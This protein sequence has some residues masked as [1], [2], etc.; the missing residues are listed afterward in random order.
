MPKTKVLCLI[1]AVVIAS[2]GTV[3][4]ALNMGEE[5]VPPIKL[6]N[7]VDTVMDKP[8]G[9]LPSDRSA[10]ENLYIAQ[11]ELQRKG[12]YV[13]T[14]RGTAVSAGIA[15]DV[16]NNRVVIGDS[17]FKEM[18]TIGV[19]KNA[20]QLYISGD[21]YLHRKFDNIKSADNIKWA[22]TAA[23]YSKEGFLEK[24]GHFSNRLTGYILNDETIISGVLEKEENGL[25]TYRYV[26]NTETAPA[27]MLYE[28]RTNSNMRGFSVF[29][30]AE[31]IVTMD[32]D[33][34]VKTLTTDCKYK[35]PMF[36]GVNCV[37]DV[38]ETFGDLTSDVLPET[39]F[40]EQFLDAEIEKPVDAQPDALS[41]LMD[42]FSPYAGGNNLNVSLDAAM[43]GQTVLSGL[44]SAK[45][46]IENISNIEVAAKIGN[47]LFVEYQ[48]GAIYVTYQDFKA[49]TT[50][51]GIM[52]V[53]N[54][55]MPNA[56]LTDSD[57]ES[58][59][60]DILSKFTYKV[61]DDLCTVNL[62]LDLGGEQLNVNIYANV[63]DGKYELRNAEVTL[64]N[65]RLAIEPVG[66]FEVPVREG[67]YPE[68]LGLFDLVKNG[69]I[70]GN[71]SAFGMDVDVMFDIAT[72]SLYATSDNLAL[73]VTYIDKTI[74]AEF[75]A[76]KAKLNIDDIDSIMDLLRLIGVADTDIK[77]EMP[78]IS[79]DGIIAILGNITTVATDSG[80]AFSL[81][82]DDLSVA[83]YLEATANGW[84]VDKLTADIKGNVIT[85]AMTEPVVDT[86]PEVADD[87]Y[88]D[89]LEIITTF[90][91]PV[92]S[93]ALT[94]SYGANFA[95]ALTVN[96]V[97]Y[98]IEGNF[99]YDI[100]KNIRVAATVSNG[101]ATVL[102]ANVTV[103][104]NTV[105]LDV[106]GLKAALSTDMFG[107]ADVDIAQLINGIYGVSDEIDGIINAVYGI[108]NTALNLD[109]SA[110]D[111]AN[112]VKEFG[113]V[114]GKLALTVNADFVGLSDI[115]IA[116]SVN[117][118]GNLVVDLNGLQLGNV[119]LDVNATVLTNV[120]N[121]VAPS[122]D[123]YVLNLAGSVSNV[124]FAVS[125]DLYNMDISASIDVLGQTV[126]ARYVDGKI[127]AAVGK[128]AVVAN[129]DQ[130]GALIT[131]ITTAIGA[132]N[133]TMPA[134]PE[135]DLS[136]KTLIQAITL[137]INDA[138]PSIGI[139]LDGLANVSVNFDNDANFVNITATAFNTQLEVV[140]VDKRV[141]QLDLNKVYIPVEPLAAQLVEIYNN[142]KDVLATGIAL[143]VNTTVN[144]NGS[145]YALN[146]IV[147]YNNGLYV[148]A[149]IADNA[150]KLVA[151]D[152]YL[153]NNALYLDV[154]GIRIATELP[155][156]D[157][158]NS[159][160]VDIAT[161]FGAL[162]Q[163]KGYNDVL[164]SIIA[165][166]EQLPERF[167]GINYVDLL[168]ALTY[169]DNT[170][171]ATINGSILGLSDFAVTV[172]GT[173]NLDV[174]LTNLAIGNVTIDSLTVNANPA[175]NEVVAP[176]SE[177]VT[178]LE[179]QVAGLTVTAKLDL[180]NKTVVAKTTLLNK[181]LAL[182][183]VDNAIYV[184]Y[185]G[186][187]ANLN[188]ADIDRL[189]A[190]VN[191]FADVTMP[192]LN[193]GVD[194][195]AIVNSLAL[196]RN[197]NGY[198]IAIAING[199][200]V[201]AAF[202]NNARLTTAQIKVGDLD[203]TATLI[204]GASYPVFDMSAHYDNLADIA[205]TYATEIKN[206]LDAEGYGVTLDG[207]FDIN[208]NVYGVT[209]TVNY[210]NGL[211]VNAT[212]AYNANDV[213]RA[214]LWWVDGAVYA[215][216]G[217][218]VRFAVNVANGNNAKAG[219]KAF[220][221]DS[222]KGYNDTLDGVLS[223]IEDVIA[224][225]TEST[226]NYGNLLGSI[227]Y[228]NGELT[229]IVNGQEIG[230]S[231]IGLQLAV[232]NG[233]NA[234]ITNLVVGDVTAN[235]TATV[236]ASDSAVVAPTGDFT[237]NLAIKIDN[238]NTVYANLDLIN[239]VFNFRLD[240]MYI[241]YANNT[242]RINK[243]DMY[244]S[245]D[246]N[247][248]MDLVNR[249]DE[250]VNEFS[251]ATDSTM[252]KLDM[253]MFKNIDVKAIVKSLTIT[254]VGNGTSIGVKAFGFDI[255][256]MF[257]NGALSKASVPVSML[258]TTLEVTPGYAQSYVEFSDDIEYVAIDQILEDYFPVFEKLVHTNAW[259]FDFD[260]NTELVLSGKTYMVAAGSYFE[261]YFKNTEGFDTFKLRAH[262]DVLKYHS[263]TKVWQE[264]MLLDIVYK[265][266]NIYVSDTGRKVGNQARNTI[267]ITV[268]VDSILKC[269]GL[270]K[271]LVAVV[272]QIGE[273][274]DSVWKAMK[275]AETSAK[276]LSY[277]NILSDIK[278]SDGIVGLVLNGTALLSKLEAISFTAQTNGDGLQ[279]NYLELVYDTIS[280]TINNLRV[281]ASETVE[282]N[283]VTDYEVVHDID[284][285]DTTGHM[286]FN[287]LYELLSAF[288]ATATPQDED[289]GT[290]SFFIDGTATVALK[291]IGLNV[292]DID[293]GLSVKVDINEDN[294]VFITVKITRTKPSGFG[295]VFVDVYNDKGG[296]SYLY[297]DGVNDT[298]T[299]IRNS[300]QSHNY[301]SKCK[302][303]DN[304][305]NTVLHTA[306]R[307]NQDIID[308]EFYGYPSYR[309]DNITS[310]EFTAD[311]MDYIFELFNFGSTIKD[312]IVKAIQEPNSNDFG[313]EDIL[314]GYSY[315]EEEK[316]FAFNAD[317]T[318]IDSNLGAV[319]VDI[320]HDDNFNLTNLDVGVGLLNG[321]CNAKIP[322]E[323][324]PSDYGDATAIVKQTIF[325]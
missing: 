27:R 88:A 188:L 93:I 167:D 12:G 126:L 177:Y 24:F 96:G 230:L 267:K 37:E 323:L 3:S 206:L 64:G 181:E 66:E 41:V 247:R 257:V 245:G 297:Y 203:V 296:D 144:V 321:M 304:C 221:F 291:I 314:K 182:Y 52:G 86:I 209:A 162:A 268:S 213:I 189:I 207:Q 95:F 231:Q 199:I 16:Y 320:R 225:F 19:V 170:L 63:V 252:A 32:A 109:V 120:N 85:L 4:L 129:L 288:V 210:N 165:V 242:L 227:G 160:N 282:E 154:N 169:S 141:P 107:G 179:V 84:N 248:I 143:N 190:V 148:N 281:T 123:D 17:A 316:I 305:S 168:G 178:E 153:V 158:A 253:S 186:I 135:I 200:N 254:T 114:N 77:L 73:A 108:V 137:D 306:W 117:R 7:A 21:N 163:V 159:S 131:E 39:D 191:M 286:D 212:I 51:D 315:N 83:I 309:V 224:R 82:M 74:Y 241:Q 285:Y 100:N 14:T 298:F 61:E 270:Y 34:Q 269:A 105:Y 89:V 98:G 70:S 151:L 76:I 149:N 250:L 124:Q 110:I 302:K 161:V 75:G 103:A 8:V 260:G 42:I 91:E 175:C 50:V 25:Y 38:T 65:M 22:D 145:A 263:D 259:R 125:A 284:D 90:I 272:P 204:T 29:S 140:A 208:G 226:V 58:G 198:S 130:L 289:T 194:V 171:S 312:P 133:V 195:K 99:A 59:E 97:T 155:Q 240:D 71:V 134:L 223:V 60:N 57:D 307:K 236:A 279:L 87:E 324:K 67:D 47:D 264:F 244:V 40:F 78:Q 2:A 322:F 127:Y 156:M 192:Q 46:D 36:G 258:K 293:I 53:V 10:I 112:I 261:F 294:K 196:I 187:S 218:N 255:N 80:V 311:I 101:V 166:I 28:M 313:L 128:V 238:A 5:I 292:A 157:N 45:I 222:F 132:D 72:A 290:R 172:A 56:P 116:L 277:A 121:V 310:V 139:E 319:N 197:E 185:D 193:G 164:D 287:S 146:A 142:Y 106:N 317:L 173:S 49:S 119:G 246:I 81:S 113:F 243:G 300:I 94:D 299:V 180:Y 44:V 102:K 234:N 35:V 214:E 275:E 278:Y 13:G 235:L 219:G 303:Y 325:W 232:N 216:I 68:I 26:L 237:T 48:Q 118:R 30:K 229:L 111:F 54:A 274:V 205:E 211:Y 239:N 31:I 215:Q 301:C 184:R 20:Y 318:A 174:T 62:P 276:K 265:D 69:V 266:G 147:N 11:G 33:W 228:A 256:A 280:L 262:L 201:E 43:D 55:L 18:I 217:N 6:D 283:G 23:R 150:N 273:L 251:G 104:D 295:T 233:V 202:N 1:L 115:D 79:L 271:D 138:T 308:T 92:A 176:T 122:V 9:E 136:L 15:Q 152:M 249:I 183:Y 220:S